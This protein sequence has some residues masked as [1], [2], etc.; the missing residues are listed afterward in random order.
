MPNVGHLRGIRTLDVG[1]VAGWTVKAD[2]AQNLFCEKPNF[3]CPPSHPF[4]PIIVLFGWVPMGGNESRVIS[5]HH[6]FHSPFNLESICFVSGFLKSEK[7][8]DLM[9][10]GWPPLIFRWFSFFTYFTAYSFVQSEINP[11]PQFQK[12]FPLFY[13]VPD[14]P[15]IFQSLLWNSGLSEEQ[16]TVCVTQSSEPKDI[17]LKTGVCND[18]SVS[19]TICPESSFCFLQIY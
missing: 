8:Y 14:F 18:I 17:R 7:I 1:S 9:I 2:T 16:I 19:W 3:L 15:P 11:P 6:I 13:Y 5:Q 10:N 4:Y 12:V